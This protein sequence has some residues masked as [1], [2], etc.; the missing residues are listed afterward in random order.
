MKIDQINKVIAGGLL[1]LFL[2]GCSETYLDTQPSEKI[3]EQDAT[4]TVEN[5][6][7]ILNG[8]HSYNYTNWEGQDYNGEHSFNILRDMLGEDVINSTTGNGWYIGEARWIEHR[9]DRGDASLNPWLIYYNMILNA[10][11]ILSQIDKP[12]LKGNNDLKNRIKGEALAYRAWCHFQLVQLYGKRYQNGANNDQLGVIIRDSVSRSEK[13][14]A[15]VEEVYRFINNDLD[16]AITLLKTSSLSAKNRINYLTALGIKSR[17]SLVQQNWDA[18]S[19]FATE[20]IALAKERNIVLQSKEGLLSGFNDWNKNTEWIWAYKQ[21]P[22]QS[23]YYGHFNAYMSWNFNSSNIRANP[24]LMNKE[25]YESM[26]STD[27]RRMWWDPGTMNG[28]EWEP[29]ESFEKNFPRPKNYGRKAYSTF[30][31][32]A[33]DYGNSGGDILLMRLAELYYIAA[34]AY[35]H[36][37]QNENAQNLLNE[38]MITRDPGYVKSTQTGDALLEEIWKNRRIDLWGEGFRFTDLKRLNQPLNRTVVSNTPTNVSRKMEVPAD[39]KEWQFLIPKKEMDS[40]PNM[41]QN[42]L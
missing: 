24:K 14:R 37:G 40:N 36:A 31:F 21:A 19:K 26:S 25:L 18:A 11:G 16:Q 3:G 13:P 5:L 28:D 27:I 1:L 23:K 7:Y 17:V 39:S 9:S 35:A 38:I 15:T 12:D 29:S 2:S 30:K 8:M 10:N 22:D 34:E 6:D 20:A 4:A 41:K 33:Q 42:E 32:T